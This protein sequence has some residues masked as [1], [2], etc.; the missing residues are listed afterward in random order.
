MTLALT[1]AVVGFACVFGFLN[2]FRD[3]STAVGLTV[4]TR[5][6]TPSIAVVLA[7][8]FNMAGVVSGAW[9]LTYFGGSWL[10][11]PD[12]AR[13]LV[14]LLAT[15]AS[16]TLWNVFLWWR[17]YPS[18]ST[19]ALVGGLAG[20]S[21][22][23]LLRGHGTGQS[24]GD[25]L[26]LQVWLPLLISPLLAFGASFFLTSLV[27]WLARYSQPSQ[28]HAALRAA[29]SVGTAA[30]AFGHGL[31]DGQR[32]IAVLAIATLGSGVNWS[33]VPMWIVALSALVFGVGT[34]SGGWRI[35]YTLSHRLVRTDPLRG[36]VSQLVTTA[37]L[38]FGALGLRWPLS[39]THTVAASILGAGTNQSFAAVDGRLL[40]RLIL[41]WIATP[42]ATAALGLVFA[43]ALEPLG[44]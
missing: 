21:L 34:L 25:V 29:Q 10:T 38:F 33:A 32:V 19:H 16:A 6:L 17:G 24:L 26:W 41:F 3:A 43:L 36:F 4:R 9:L 44:S 22:A 27:T 12:G 18:S 2:G 8:V 13:G 1:V 23:A 15:L 11:A 14:L 39:T 28:A 37:T 20:A 40:V 30:V 35:T 7:A 31:Q 5:A 42:L